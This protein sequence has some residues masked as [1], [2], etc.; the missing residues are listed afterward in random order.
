MLFVFLLNTASEAGR[1]IDFWNLFDGG[2]C[3]VRYCPYWWETVS[4]GPG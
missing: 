3:Y 2:G 1:C 4:G